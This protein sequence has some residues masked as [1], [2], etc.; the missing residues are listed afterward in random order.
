MKAALLVV[1]LVLIF[2][3]TARADDFVDDDRIPWEAEFTWLAD[4]HAVDGCAPSMV[5]PQRV[6][7]R[8]EAAKMLALAGAAEGMWEIPPAPDAIFDDVAAAWNGT[9]VPFVDALVSAGVVSGCADG[10]F[11][12]YRNLTR[13]EATEMIVRSFGLTAPAAW[14]ASFD[15][16]AGTFYAD[17]ALVAA[18]R[19]LW[20]MRSGSLRGSNPITR[21]EFA[22]A[23]VR[24]A[25]AMLCTSDPFTP[26]RVAALAADHPYQRFTAY[27][28]DERTGCHYAMHPEQ[29]QSTAS[30]F[31]VMV[32]AGTLYE[33]QSAGRGPTGWEVAQMDPMITESANAP[34]RALWSS[35][36]G[37]PWFAE[38]ARL[39]GLTQ[40]ATVG[41]FERGWG[42]TKTS[43]A[44]QVHLLRQVILGHG[45]L[46]QP[47]HRRWALDLMSSVVPEQQWGV[48]TEA[49][50]GSTVFQKNGFAGVTAN[51]VGVVRRSDGTHYVMAVLTTGWPSWSHG[52][53][54]V[55]RVAGWVHD[56]IGD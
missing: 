18:Y 47:A 7:T 6:I 28:W 38:Q 8:L 13:G 36:G 11:C 40:T 3:L 19:D 21:A 27:A 37:A 43:A 22:I 31:K 55:D 10:R 20:P 50:E 35:F 39:F 9:G 29:R 2:P 56:S 26:W 52:V 44:D 34:V 25:G 5:C 54:A 51:G 12:P 17:E 4:R 33:A 53:P 48:G 32:M 41:D 23:L 16:V 30:V 14:S 45:G 24:A 15:D 42:A 46:L 49:P 1:V